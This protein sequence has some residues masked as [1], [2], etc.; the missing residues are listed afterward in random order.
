MTV[1]QQPENGSHQLW[2]IDTSSLLAVRE[3]YGASRERAVFVALSKYATRRKLFY[4]PEVWRELERAAESQ[5]NPDAALKWVRE[6]RHCSE[7]A[8]DGATIRRVLAKVPE[9]LDVDN[10]NEQADCYVLAVGV[11]LSVGGFDVCIITDDRRD[12]GQHISLAT[13]TGMFRLPNVPLHA[14]VRGE[15]VLE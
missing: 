12:K 2:V 9:L 15:G 11:D 10:P 8:A 13:A 5:T 6:H 3:I 1:A 14:F 7:R 4:P